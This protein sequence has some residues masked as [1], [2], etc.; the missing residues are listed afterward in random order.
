MPQAGVGQLHSVDGSHWTGIM[1]WNSKLEQ[2]THLFRKFK[3]H[4]TINNWHNSMHRCQHIH[5]CTKRYVGVAGHA[6][7]WILVFLLAYSLMAVAGKSKKAPISSDSL[8]EFISVSPVKLVH[9]S[10]IHATREMFKQ[11]SL[12]LFPFLIVSCGHVHTALLN[13][14]WCHCNKHLKMILSY[15][16]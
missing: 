4:V 2:W 12:Y 5:S 9:C 11:V 6:C 13:H 7:G 16:M 8:T 3:I 15:I 14:L 1:N 10:H